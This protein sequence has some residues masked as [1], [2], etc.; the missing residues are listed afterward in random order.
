MIFAIIRSV[1]DRDARAS[2]KG[3]Y[4]KRTRAGARAPVV[5]GRG[6][7]RESAFPEAQRAITLY[8]VKVSG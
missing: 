7:V 1:D 3:R 5:P 6:M 2:Q 4:E 8:T